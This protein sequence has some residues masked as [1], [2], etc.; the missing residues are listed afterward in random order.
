MADSKRQEI[1]DQ[2]AARLKTIKKNAGYETDLGNNVYDWRLNPWDSS[3][4]PG[5]MYRDEEESIEDDLTRTH[6]VTMELSVEAVGLGTAQISSAELAR[7]MLADIVKAFGT[8]TKWTKSGVQLATRTLYRGSKM[9]VVQ[10]DL[11]AVAVIARF[12][13][14]YRLLY[15]DSYNQAG[16]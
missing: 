5:V 3:T 14:Q 2:I 7:K 9:G 15:F 16:Q 13:I 11:T 1:L 12:S 6:M 10:K 8:D 4:M